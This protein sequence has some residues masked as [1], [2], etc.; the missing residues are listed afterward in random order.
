[1]PSWFWSWSIKASL[2]SCVWAALILGVYCSISSC[3]RILTLA[4]IASVLLSMNSLRAFTASISAS[5]EEL[6]RLVAN[7]QSLL[8]RPTGIHLVA[9][10]TPAVKAIG[11]IFCHAARSLASSE[12][13]AFITAP[14]ACIVAAPIINL[15]G[16]PLKATIVATAPTVKPTLSSKS[17]QLDAESHLVSVSDSASSCS[18]VLYTGAKSS[19]CLLNSSE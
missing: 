10:V 8:R 1:M 7:V 19:H 14:L 4:F 11:R 16:T 9:A 5:P 13:N 15:A 17:A 6:M 12:V 18:L 2:S 3:L